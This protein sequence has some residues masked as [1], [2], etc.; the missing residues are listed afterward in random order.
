[1]INLV[2]ISTNIF[3]NFGK[4][5][6]YIKWNINKSSRAWNL[7]VDVYIDFTISDFFHCIPSFDSSETS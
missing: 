2:Y 1:M 5:E 6:F 4:I 3:N 7:S